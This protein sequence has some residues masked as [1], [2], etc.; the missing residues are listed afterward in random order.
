[1]I[2]Y[3]HILHMVHILTS[4]HVLQQYTVVPACPSCT[5]LHNE[6][7]PGLLNNYHYG[8]PKV[9]VSATLA[10]LTVQLFEVQRLRMLTVNSP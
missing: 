1:M 8:L 10:T 9:Y 3:W 6:S 4:A 2:G 7:L 5:P